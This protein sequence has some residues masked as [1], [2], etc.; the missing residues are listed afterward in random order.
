MFIKHP[1][2]NPRGLA[3]LS[4]TYKAGD[5]ADCAGETACGCM[6]SICKEDIWGWLAPS[7]ERRS[8]MALALASVDSPCK[9]PFAAA[10]MLVGS[11]SGAAGPVLM[12]SSDVAFGKFVEISAFM[13]PQFGIPWLRDFSAHL[14]HPAHPSGSPASPS[15][16]GVILRAARG[17]SS[18]R[19]YPSD[20]ED[21]F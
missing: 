19:G 13:G 7:F 9:S 12:F 17:T 14:A 10:V 5:C 1:N 8:V 4:R 20:I 16:F 15:L 3:K 18:N 2:L 21:V 6:T 11:T